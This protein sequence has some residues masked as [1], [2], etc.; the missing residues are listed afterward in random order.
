MEKWVALGKCDVKD[1]MGPSVWF[2][3]NNGDVEKQRC[4]KHFPPEAKG[5]ERWES[6]RKQVID[7]V[8]DVCLEFDIYL[9]ELR[10]KGVE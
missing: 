10:K 9:D 7:K 4:A 2:T 3:I 1:C 8:A 6:V 5:L